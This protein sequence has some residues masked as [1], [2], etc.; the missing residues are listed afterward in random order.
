MRV[1]AERIVHLDPALCGI[2]VLRD[3]Y[4][5][6]ILEEL[7]QV[8]WICRIDKIVELVET[9]HPLESLV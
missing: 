8:I 7:R 2:H 3:N 4:T 1:D 5:K 6:I 9:N